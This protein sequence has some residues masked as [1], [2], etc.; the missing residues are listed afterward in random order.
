MDYIE[1]VMASRP[2]TRFP[3]IGG[4]GVQICLTRR[5]E[6]RLLLHS[7]VLSLHSEWFRASLSKQWA[8]EQPAGQE[9]KKRFIRTILT[10]VQLVD[11]LKERSRVVEARRSYLGPPGQFA[12]QAGEMQQLK[13]N[14][15]MKL[16]KRFCGYTLRNKEQMK[17]AQNFYADC[18]RNAVGAIRPLWYNCLSNADDW[19]DNISP[20]TLHT[21]TELSRGLMCT[22]MSDEDLPWLGMQKTKAADS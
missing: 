7:V 11:H 10:A 20:A 6:D 21:S 3:V 22:Q 1:P 14:K 5:P 13:I 2:S 17:M 9:P 4:G 18:Y 19:T 16:E 15:D 8:S 12:G